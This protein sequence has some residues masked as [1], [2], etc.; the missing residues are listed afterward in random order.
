MEE[1]FEKFSI[2]DISIATNT[3]TGTVN[4]WVK[5][6]KIPS[7]YQF[8]I[9][10]LCSKRIEY[11]AF[12]Y[13]EKDQFFTPEDAAKYVWDSFKRIISSLDEDEKTF[14]Y[15]EPAA[16]KG[17]FL[18]F[19]PSDRTS[20]YDIEPMCPGIIELDFLDFSP[21]TTEKIVVFGNPPF[22]LR[23]HTALKFINHSSRFAEFVCFILPQLFESDGKGAPRKRVTGMNLIHSEHLD[24]DFTSPHN[25]R[26]KVNCIFQIWSKNHSN[27]VFENVST[28]ISD[29]IKVYSVSDG[30]DPG[31]RRNVRLI[32]K[33]DIFLQSTCFGIENMKYYNSFTE[34]PRSKGY[35]VIFLKNKEE[36]LKKFKEI[37]WS[38]VSFL[39]T[40]G[41]LN[42]RMSQIYSQF[43]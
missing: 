5:K 17:V 34:L 31:Q 12:S 29:C 42:L 39:S 15:I 18:D 20:A 33:C 36:N 10:K 4:R 43:T 35:G 7:A 13:R 24:T 28:T 1:A 37:V 23:G 30:A 21:G 27:P 40:N 9:M 22:G 3:T 6:N 11:S 19:L 8:D 41:A 25:T 26:V 32:C 14:S 2:K 16:G 38:S